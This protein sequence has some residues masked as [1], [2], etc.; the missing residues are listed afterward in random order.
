MQSLVF[1]MLKY[2]LRVLTIALALVI[3]CHNAE[4]QNVKRDGKTFITSS[5]SKQSSD[6]QTTYMWKDK[7]GNQYP[8]FLHK[9]TKGEKEGQWGAYVLRISAK[10]GKE[11][12]YYF[13]KNDEVASQIRK[14]DKS[15]K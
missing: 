14:E 2:I 15:I 7:E 9:Y 8:I 13:P 5:E 4:G 11:Y 6:I 3:G 10:T 12:K 1:D